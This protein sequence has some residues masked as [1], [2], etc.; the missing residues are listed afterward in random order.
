MPLSNVD[1]FRK[2]LECW[3]RHD[4]DGALSFMSPDIDYWDT[5]MT[6]FVK[7]HG[8]V[9][10]IF[11]SFFEGFP[12][13][14]FE[15]CNIFGCGENVACEWRMRG[16]QAKAMPGLDAIGKSIA[17]VEISFCTLRNG[18]ICRQIDSWDSATMMRQL[19]LSA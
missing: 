4:L 10:K 14:E 1:V 15:I 18:K 2:M 7:G 6:G 5:T 16:T 8:E 13:L 11:R 3:N 17:I 19:G 12:D 9:R